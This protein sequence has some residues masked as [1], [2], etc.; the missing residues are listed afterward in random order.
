MKS[1][2][3]EGKVINTFISKAALN[4]NDE[5]NRWKDQVIDRTIVFSKTLPGTWRTGKWLEVVSMVSQWGSHAW[6]PV[7]VPSMTVAVH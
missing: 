2:E 4:Q 3:T 6:S 7:H 5:T 1:W